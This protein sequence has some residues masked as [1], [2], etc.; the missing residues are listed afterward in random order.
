MSSKSSNPNMEN[1]YNMMSQSLISSIPLDNQFNSSIH[2]YQQNNGLMDEELYTVIT[3]GDDCDNTREIEN[4]GELI[5]EKLSNGKEIHFTPK[6][7]RK[8]SPDK[9]K[10]TR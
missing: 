7:D 8:F 1:N 2:E 9:I 10:G 3:N 4:V 5:E 6:N